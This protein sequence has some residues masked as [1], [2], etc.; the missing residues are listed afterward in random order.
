[1]SGLP[2]EFL[3]KGRF[4]EL[5]FVD[6]PD[7]KERVE[8]WKIVI[9]KYGRDP[10]DY[11]CVRLARATE[12]YTGAEIEQAYIDSLHLAFDEGGE[13]GE[14]TVGTALTEIVP[15]HSLMAEKIEALR[16][17]ARGRARNASHRDAPTNG[18]RKLD[19]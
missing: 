7:Q 5:F 14:L 8:I 2:P 16:Q 17:W 6:L 1:V 12:T 15:L 13:P 10:A 18:K 3:R 11:D 19:L 9:A 4:D